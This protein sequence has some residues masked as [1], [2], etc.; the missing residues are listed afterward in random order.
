MPSVD[1][2]FATE[3]STSKRPLQPP[4]AQAWICL[5]TVS[6]VKPDYWREVCAPKLKAKKEELGREVPEREIAAWVE[7][8]TGQP[9]G[10][11]LVNLW[12]LGLREPTVSQFVALCHKLKLDPDE[13]LDGARVRERRPVIRV[14]EGEIRS[15]KPD[16]KT[17]TRSRSR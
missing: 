17:G 15:R 14:K 12:L 5:A 4:V 8:A 1:C 9:S 2:S 11:A 7:T 6:S 10:R 3:G 13:V 16:T